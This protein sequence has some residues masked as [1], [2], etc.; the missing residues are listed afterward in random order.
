MESFV[1]IVNGFKPF[2][3]VFGLNTGKYGPEKTLHLGTFHAVYQFQFY[4]T[5]GLLKISLVDH[6]LPQKMKWL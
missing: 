4:S 6:V 1:T 3:P 2:F 5:H